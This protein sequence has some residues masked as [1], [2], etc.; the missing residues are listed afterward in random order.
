MKT[1]TKKALLTTLA[2]STL[3][4]TACSAASTASYNLSN[5]SDNF[6]VNRRI[7]FINGITDNYLME[8]EGHCSIEADGE[9]RQLEVTCKTGENDYKKHYLG[10]SDNVTYFVEQLEAKDVS[11]YHY[12]VR[13]RPK[14]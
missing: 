12:K 6:E 8:I 11:A 14:L 2:G 1:L 13:F 4:L 3:A 7:V 9:D 10:I 5:A